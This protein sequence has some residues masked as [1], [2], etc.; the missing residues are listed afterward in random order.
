M[1]DVRLYI[2]HYSEV[3]QL[4]AEDAELVAAAFAATESAY[5]PYSGFRV[6]AAVR[7]ASGR[8]ESASNQESEVFPS[9]MCAERVL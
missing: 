9:G 1:S 2:K 6:G 3:G 8:I 7:L 4:P 5:A